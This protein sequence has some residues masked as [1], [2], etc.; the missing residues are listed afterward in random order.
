MPQPRVHPS[1][2][3]L[4]ESF[5][6]SPSPLLVISAVIKG[7]PLIQLFLINVNRCLMRL[8][9][10]LAYWLCPVIRAGMFHGP[11]VRFVIGMRGLYVTEPQFLIDAFVVGGLAVQCGVSFEVAK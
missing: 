3:K 11:V 7:T 9:L 10:V 8:A 4:T 1:W 2:S 6:E 5:S